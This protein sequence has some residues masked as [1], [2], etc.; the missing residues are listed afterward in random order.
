ML[1][2][3]TLDVRM[4]L[5]GKVAIVTGAGRGIGKATASALA[6]EGANITVTDID[7]PAIQQLAKE[8]QS[9]GRESLPVKA[10]VTKFNEIKQ[11]V[12]LT[13]EKFGRVDI[14]C[15]I[16]GIL[17]GASH[18]QILNI[19]EEDWDRTLDI[20]LKGVFFCS[21]AVFKPMMNQRSGKIINIAS[22]AGDFAALGGT[23]HYA[24][25]KGGVI[26]FTKT[27]AIEGAPYGITVNAVSPSYIDT[28][29]LKGMSDQTKQSI[30]RHTLLGRLGK[31]EEVAE[32][33][34]FLASNANYSTGTVIQVQGGLMMR[35]P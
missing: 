19:T 30:I 10:D 16:A 29:L 9:M 34:V 26:A 14:L 25:S 18:P 13:V 1:A 23:V 20:N 6:K 3:P 2:I 31:P 24:A 12:D 21:K 5:N 22:S 32:A 33:V 28:D 27:L 15:N 11:M 4:K 17:S 35:L 7:V 8:L